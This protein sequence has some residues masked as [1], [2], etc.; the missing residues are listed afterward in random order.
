[1]FDLAI[2]ILM[3]AILA[4]IAFVAAL[5]VGIWIAVGAVY[6]IILFIAWRLDRR[7]SP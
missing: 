5:V 2:S 3:I 4:P 1:M 7:S 6:L